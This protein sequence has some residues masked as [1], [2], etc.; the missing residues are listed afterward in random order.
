M[1][2]IVLSFKSEITQVSKYLRLNRVRSGSII[3]EHAAVLY[4]LLLFLA[5]PLLNY[6]VIGFRSFFLWFAANEAV[7]AA[8]KAKTYLKPIEITSDIVH[9]S[10]CQLALEKANQ[11]KNMFSGISWEETKNNPDVEIVREPINPEA[12]NIQ[13]EKV[14]SRDNG[15][16]LSSTDDPDQSLYIYICRVK[17]KGQVSPLLP[18]PWFSVPGLSCPINL[19]VSSQAQFE[20]VSGLTM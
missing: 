1:L 8:S 12:K 9:P 4:A 18:I 16:P 20:N 5:F 19:T 3:V 10:A 15:A 7:M 2:E 11:I 17:I 13:Q 6:S 14:F